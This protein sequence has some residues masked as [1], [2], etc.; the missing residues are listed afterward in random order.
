MEKYRIYEKC[1]GKYK[2]ITDKATKEQADNYKSDN[3]VLIIKQTEDRDETYKLMFEKYR[4][5]E[6]EELER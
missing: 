4:N 1:F 5:K 6:D 2:L 3:R